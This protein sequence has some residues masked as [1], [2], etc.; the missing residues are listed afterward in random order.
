MKNVI[1]YTVTLSRDSYVIYTVT[2]SNNS[3]VIYTMNKPN[4]SFMTMYD[5]HGDITKI[6]FI[7]SED[8]TSILEILEKSVIK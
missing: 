8:Y 7:K 5:K 3:Y 6:V 4:N 2:L 1:K